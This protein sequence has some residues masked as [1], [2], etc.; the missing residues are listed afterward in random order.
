MQQ[1]ALCLARLLDSARPLLAGA[2]IRDC[3]SAPDGRGLIVA[4]ANA[5]GCRGML[6]SLNA[7]HSR[8]HLL[9]DLPPRNAALDTHLVMVARQKLTGGHIREIEQPSGERLLSIATTRRDFTGETEEYRLIAELMG[10]DSNLLV[11]D[12]DGTILATWRIAHAYD[13]AYRE[14]RPGKTYVPPPPPGRLPMQPLPVEEWRR[15][16]FQQGPERPWQ[17]LLL[18]TFRGLTPG[19]IQA[20]CASADIPPRTPVG[21]L[22]SAQLHHWAA[23]IEDLWVDVQQGSRLP[24]WDAWLDFNADPRTLHQSAAELFA[25][26]EAQDQDRERADQWRAAIKAREKDLQTL[27]GH[28]LEDLYAHRGALAHRRIGDLIFAQLHLFPPDRPGYDLTLEVPDIYATPP[29]LPVDALPEDMSLEELE[30]LTNPAPPQVAIT[31][32]ADKSAQQV[33]REAYHRAGRAQR[34]ITEVNA[35]LAAVDQE[36]YRLHQQQAIWE[37]YLRV[38]PNR[39]KQVLTALRQGKS[40]PAPPSAKGA[41]K[42]ETKASIVPQGLQGISLQVYQLPDD[43]IAFVGGNAHANEVLWRYGEAEHLWLHAKGVPGSHVL[44]PLPA[45][46]VTAEALLEAARLAVAHS[47][48]KEGTKIPVDYTRIRYLKKPPGTAPGYVTY[49]RERS[50]LVD[51]F[52]PLELRRRRLHPR[53]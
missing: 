12:A 30:R 19:L 4:L 9:Q 51:P 46:Q 33:A 1:D 8:W 28:L 49:T 50:L 32:P 41:A 18:A 44:I 34:G 36:L 42:S 6:F 15:F 3:Q 13:N 27:R 43:T 10:P 53:P 52:S 48:V 31:I 40:L 22:T 47:S 26:W 2:I 38:E 17:G 16:A 21:S 37:E 39:W 29:E 7:R 5:Q 14:I 35:R 24:P 20:A 45:H 25:E 11:L 23:A